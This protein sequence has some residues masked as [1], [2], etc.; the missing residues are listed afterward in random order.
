MLG[1][2]QSAWYERTPE[3]VVLYKQNVAALLLA[4]VKRMS[5]RILLPGTVQQHNVRARP[6]CRCV[7]SFVRST[8]YMLYTYIPYI[9]Y[10]THRSRYSISART[11]RTDRTRDDASPLPPDV[12]ASSA[13]AGGPVAILHTSR[14]YMGVVTD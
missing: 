13:S 5:D 8:P 1:P 11:D 12:F 3:P 4:G 14:M 2:L 6:N 10:H 7:R 9:L